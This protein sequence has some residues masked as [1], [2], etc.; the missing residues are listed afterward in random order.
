M[1]PLTMP[2]LTINK[3]LS[4]T[5]LPNAYQINSTNVSC[6][7]YTNGSLVL[8]RYFRSVVIEVGACAFSIMFQLALA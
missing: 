1:P 2:P 7:I 6:F 8:C 4:I 5:S 3:W